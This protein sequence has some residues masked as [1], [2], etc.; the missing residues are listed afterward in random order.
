MPPHR[1][2]TKS[3]RLKGHIL[4]TANQKTSALCH[5]K[6]SL[7]ISFIL[8]FFFIYFYFSV[9]L[10]YFTFLLFTFLFDFPWLFSSSLSI[11]FNLFLFISLKELFLHF[12]SFLFLS[13]PFS[14]GKFFISL[15]ISF[16]LTKCQLSSSHHS[17][18]KPDLFEFEGPQLCLLCLLSSQRSRRAVRYIQSQ[19]LHLSCPLFHTVN[20][21]LCFKSHSI[22]LYSSFR[23]IE[24]NWTF[25]AFGKIIWRSALGQ[26]K[27]SPRLKGNSPGM[28]KRRDWEAWEKREQ[29]IRNEEKNKEKIKIR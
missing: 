28:K 3:L 11:S 20:M 23:R 27:S 26:T 15:S 2:H 16:P 6:T 9:T 18:C 17:G 21:F 10:F 7:S 5:Q 24:M 19:H 8:Y 22:H 13:L 14:L 1:S 4:R 25:M 29:N 12:S